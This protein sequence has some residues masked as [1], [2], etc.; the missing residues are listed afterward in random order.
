MF[1]ARDS[2][3]SAIRANLNPVLDHSS[4]LALSWYAHR[5][6]T[7]QFGRRLRGVLGR[8]GFCRIEAS[9]SCDSYGTSETV[10]Q[11]AEVIVR[12]NQHADFV[13]FAIESGQA[14]LETLDRMKVAWKEWGEHPDSFCT[15]VPHKKVFIGSYEPC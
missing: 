2:D 7:L 5:G 3:F 4:E 15:H 6:T 12:V 11:F 9:A 10:K 1:G 8:A 14:D 13:K